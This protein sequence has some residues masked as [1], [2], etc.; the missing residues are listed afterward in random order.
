MAALIL[1]VVSVFGLLLPVSLAA[2]TG[3]TRAL[4]L[5][6]RGDYA[7]AVDAYR[8]VLK[9]RPADPS[10]LL[11]LERS[12]LPLNRSNEMLPALR[13]ALAAA[14]MSPAV[15]GIAL[16]TWAAADQL[17]SVRS[18]AERWARIAPTDE[19]PYREWG[20]AELGRQNRAGA[21]TAYLRGRQRL[22]RPDAMAAEL[23][24]LALAEGDYEQAL[25]EWLL[26]VRRLPG[27]RATAVSTLGQAPES[28]RADL[29]NV[30]TA[31]SD[32]VSR[33]LEAE[34][35]I[36]WGDPAGGLRVLTAAMPSDPVQSIAALRGL[37]DQL[38][39]LRTSEGKRVQG[40][41]LEALADR[42]PPAQASRLRLEAA[43]AYSA[44]GDRDAAHRMLGNL[45]DDR[46]APAAI[47]SGAAATL[48][49]VLI[50]E[51]K[52]DEALKR[53]AELRPNVSA[54]Q[55]DA[56]RRKIALGLMHAG[57]LVRADSTIAADSS[58]EG[59]ALS[60]RVHLYRGDIRG[61]MERFKAAG[62]YTGDRVEATRRTALLAL[63]QP[64]QT[65]SQ[66]EL[67]Q[68]LLQLEQGDTSRAA[69]GLEQVA[70]HLPPQHGGA[71]LN[72]L[73]GRLLLGSGKPVEAERL[74]RAAAVH[75]APTTAP[76]AELA[77]AELMVSTHRPGEAV[78]VLEHLILTYPQSALV[79]QARRKLDEARGA[80]PKT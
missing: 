21:R 44:A 73:A 67:G 70:A 69:A 8:A 54:D 22:G 51:N 52:L 62:P 75:D 49:G 65:D 26:A 20:A 11:G 39:T 42:S 16:R 17:D 36:R 58:V 35:R 50:S 7:A 78:D 40:R 76:A 66:P 4:D 43:Q 60:G 41:V 18:I 71:E 33:R 13:T 37:L 74:L 72:L 47:S 29:L 9:P 61:A 63:L 68:A 12:L 6:R 10:A 31:E 3:M 19:T 2:Q 14:P 64:F 57:E 77:L 28:S 32:L 30:L 48:V 1:S 25:R 24:Q 79:P 46:G 23:A 5:E 15:Y 55:Y 53:L 45:A 56:L 27:Y 34:L 80:V 38:R 59:L